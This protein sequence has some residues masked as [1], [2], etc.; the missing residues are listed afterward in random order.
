MSADPASADPASA[1]PAGVT[2]R[3]WAAARAAAGRSEESVAPGTLAEIVE[4]C[5]SRH[6]ERLAEVLGYCA[7][8]VDGAR[9]RTGTTS[10]PS[11][12]VLEVLPPFA[13]G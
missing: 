6:G 13:G 8:L 9:V 12:S 5:G 1:N 11:G 2:V 3:Y 7:F 10:I 4:R